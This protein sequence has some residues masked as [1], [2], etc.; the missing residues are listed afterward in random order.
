[1]GKHG[2]FSSRANSRG[3]LQ[4]EVCEDNGCEWSPFY[5]NAVFLRKNTAC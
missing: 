2:I 1:M 4:V 5:E 3:E